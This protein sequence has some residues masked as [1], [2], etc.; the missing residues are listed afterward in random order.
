MMPFLLAEFANLE[1]TLPLY[2]CC[3]GSHDQHRLERP[4]GYPAHQIFLCRSGSGLFRL[5]GHSDQTL[6]PGMAFLLPAGTPHSYAPARPQESWELG[7]AAFDG[8]AAPALLELMRPFAMKAFRAAN[9]EDLWRQLEGLWQ[10][11]SLNGDNAYWEASRRMYGMALAMLEGQS[12]QRRAARPKQAGEP[13]NAALQTAVRL[14]HSHYNERL[15]VSNI[16]RAAGYSAQHFNRLFVRH[17]GVSPQKYLMQLKMRRAVQLFGDHP[18][19][20]VEEAARQLG[21]D[22]TYF[23]RMFKRVYGCTP[24]QYAKRGSTTPANDPG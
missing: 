18:E 7:F 14:M 21:M 5:P 1:E 17:Y 15:L 4:Q 13:G 3:V 20:S 22:V 9:F 8:K 10:L 24:K 23:I 12:D 6:T 2:V 11:I 19:L 16:A